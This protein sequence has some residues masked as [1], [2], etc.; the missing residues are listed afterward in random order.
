MPIKARKCFTPISPSRWVSK[1]FLTCDNML[2]VQFRRGQHIKKVLPHGPGA[3]LG[4]GGVPHV[5]CLYPG[6]QG[7]WAERLYQLAEVWS[8]GGEWLH[9]FLY[10]KF[11]YQLVAPPDQCGG[12]AT[13]CSLSLNP[14]GP[15]DGQ[16]VDVICTVTNTDGSST[17]GD[18]PKGT[19]TFYVDG[20]EIGSCTLPDEPETDSQN[21]AACSIGWTASCQ[22]SDSHYVSAVYKP[23]NEEFAQTSCGSSIRVT[24]GPCVPCPDFAKIPKTIHAT[25]SDLGGCSCLAGTYPLA[26]NGLMW[27]YTAADGPCDYLGQPLGLEILFQ[28]V[29][30]GEGLFCATLVLSCGP[31]GAEV[32]ANRFSCSPFEAEFWNFV[33]NPPPQSCCSGTVNV[34]ITA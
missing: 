12:C 15:S 1:V 2:A 31:A 9:A 33:P 10:K 32:L 11:G 22:P 29:P 21:W 16:A 30:G 28:C 6:T 19:V 17:K 7:E 26:W 4:Q 20:G 3:Y 34:S 13:S 25:I 18:A 23:A 5:T 14:A 24:C 27:A 8:Y